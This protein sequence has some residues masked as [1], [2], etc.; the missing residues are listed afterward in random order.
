MGK[1]TFIYISLLC[2]AL[3]LLSLFL[4]AD[5]DPPFADGEFEFSDEWKSRQALIPVALGREPADLVIQG[6]QAF[7]AHTGEFIEGAAVRRLDNCDE[8]AAYRL[9]WSP[10]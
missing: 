8:G 4:L 7:V 5:Q 1:R 6:G 2:G 9:F 3:G 10:G